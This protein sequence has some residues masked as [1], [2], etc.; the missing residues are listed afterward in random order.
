[1]KLL[2]SLFVRILLVFDQCLNCE[3]RSGGTLEAPAENEFG[4]F[5]GR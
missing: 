1:M 4:A 2:A 5:C 3:K